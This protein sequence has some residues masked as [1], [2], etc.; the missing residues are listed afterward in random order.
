MS[1]L[2]LLVVVLPIIICTLLGVIG[3]NNKNDE[4]V[5]VNVINQQELAL[6]EQPLSPAPSPLTTGEG[7]E[8]WRQVGLGIAWLNSAEA[9]ANSLSLSRDGTTIA[10]GQFDAGSAQAGGQVNVFRYDD[11]SGLWK[12]LGQTIISG[13]SVGRFG[14]SVSLNEDGTVLA[15]GDADDGSES[16]GL[17][18]VFEFLNE[19]WVQLGED[20]HGGEPDR[21]AGRSVAL[22]D[23]GLMLALDV[24]ITSRQPGPPNFVRVYRYNGNI[25]EQIGQDVFGETASISDTFSLSLSGDGRTFAIAAV[26]PGFGY[27]KTYTLNEQGTW[28]LQGEIKPNGEESIGL[29]VSLSGDGTSLATGIYQ[30]QSSNLVRIFKFAN[31]AWSQSGSDIDTKGSNAARR[32]TLSMSTNGTTVAIGPQ[33]D[34]S[35]GRVHSYDVNKQQWSQIGENIKADPL[36]TTGFQ[37][38]SISLSGAGSRVAV[39]GPSAD[40][41]KVYDDQS[42]A[43]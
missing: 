14:Y 42:T 40:K 28:G 10:T 24:Q 17:V 36:K 25:W 39:F 32:M 26:V 13:R 37:L 5:A 38:Q 34:T 33:D 22:S 6:I 21:F 35:Y 7:N 4:T 23:D 15:I 27:L 11:S 30:F 18:I 29:S 43:P 20:I 31:G 12:P 19:M 16:T 2:T 1:V 41:V 3:Q 9:Y 8:I